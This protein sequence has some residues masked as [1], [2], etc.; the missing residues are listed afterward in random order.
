MAQLWT[1][2]MLPLNH[3]QAMAN[4]MV[5]LAAVVN[6]MVLAVALALKRHKLNL[7]HRRLRLQLPQH[8]GSQV[9]HVLYVYYLGLYIHSI[10]ENF[11]AVINV[12]Y[13]LSVS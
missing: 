13:M 3:P 11:F 1:M 10:L 6:P 12:T 2:V 5:V 4:P 9:L 8:L 7:K